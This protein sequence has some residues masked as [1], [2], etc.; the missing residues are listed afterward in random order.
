MLVSVYAVNGA[1]GFLPGFAQTFGIL[2]VVNLIDR[3][4]IDELWVCHSGAWDI[5]GT[6]DL[7]P[8]ISRRDKVQK[9]LVGTVGYAALSAILAGVM[10][11]VL[12]P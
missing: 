11:L 10:A 12:Q 3:L 9:W 7:K 6:E 4:L 5:P 1:R 2:S 8:Y